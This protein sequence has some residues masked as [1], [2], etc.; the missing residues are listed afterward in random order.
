MKS[1]WI[2]EDQ[3]VEDHPVLSTLDR[4]KDRLLFIESEAR[5]RA[6]PYHRQ[7]LV[8]L[9]S[10]MRHYAEQRRQEGWHVDYHCVEDTP[11]Y[12]PAL[13]T[14]IKKSKP[15]RILLMEP[16]NHFEAVAIQKIA[17]SLQCTLQIFPTNLFLVPRE[18]FATWAQGKKRLL[19]EAHYRRMRSELG[20]LLEP[21]GDPAGGQWNFDAENRG[22][23]Q[24]WR[25]AGSPMPQADP[26]SE[27]DAMTRQVIETVD[28]LFADHPGRAADFWVPV[29]RKE[30]L[31]WLERFIDTR[32]PEFGNWQDL[33]LNGEYTFFHS[34][35]S[36]MINIGLLHPLECVAKAECAFRE[37]RAPL[38]AV[39]AFIRQ[40]IGWREFVNGIYWLKMP[41]YAE[42]NAL[43]AN[44]PL[45]EFFWTGETD[46]RCV[47]QCVKQVL[48]TG[49]NHHIQRLMILGNFFLL[50]EIRP[51]EVLRWFSA[52]YLDAHDWVMAANVLGMVLH[53]D[54]GFMATK[55]YAASAA[56]ISRMS[57]YC[58]GCKYHPDRKTGEG[59]CP[60]NLLYWNFYDRH[61]KRFANNPRTAM[62]VRSWLKRNPADKERIIREAA[63]FLDQWVPVTSK[64]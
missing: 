16:N 6:L 63:E 45:P 25:K 35:I 36:P 28:N 43:E 31:E 17:H 23:V 4:T 2:L 52:L 40:I 29:T 37:G 9:F 61:A 44:R 57:N 51:Q 49:Y 26:R 5:A 60:F 7:R 8:L 3:L 34:V 20:I 62:P 30:S 47:G 12:L 64:A 46:M 13:E 48:A 15:E 10:A 56:Y 27:P 11:Q 38:A 41:E 18:D 50:A 53:A 39:E 19:M 24:D 58:D 33:M 42:S 54:G 14:H 55:P 1:L 21:N 59:A 32:L 22:G